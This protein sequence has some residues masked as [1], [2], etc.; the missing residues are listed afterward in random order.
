VSTEEIAASGIHLPVII[1][2]LAER[3]QTLEELAD[4]ALMFFAA[5]EVSKEDAEKHLTPSALSA[6]G[7]LKDLMAVCPWDAAGISAA[8]KAVVA[9]S[10]L[11]MPQIAVPLRLKVFGKTQTPSIDATLAAMKRDAVLQR[12]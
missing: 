8:I 6:L 9:S 2:L 10:G 4:Q 7:A 12:L 1:G 3:S 5:G 11:K